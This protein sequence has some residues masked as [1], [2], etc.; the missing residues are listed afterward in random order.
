MIVCVNVYLFTRVFAFVSGRMHV[1]SLNYMG[2]K[3][4][5]PPRSGQ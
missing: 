1:Q 5:V 2:G 3:I 4:L